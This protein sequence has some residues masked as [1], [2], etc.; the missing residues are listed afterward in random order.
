MNTFHNNF[1][2]T[3][4]ATHKGE[5]DIVG[6]E[7]VRK[8]ERRLCG[9]D[10]CTCSDEGGVRGSELAFEPLTAFAYR[11]VRVGG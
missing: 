4:Y 8:V 11:I 2:N 10:R 6:R 7:F 9:I 3:K 5:G 1:H